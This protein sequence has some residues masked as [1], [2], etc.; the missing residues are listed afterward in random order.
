MGFKKKRQTES[1]ENL[2]VPESIFRMIDEI[3]KKPITPEAEK[4]VEE[5]WNRFQ[6]NSRKQRIGIIKKRMA[7]L[8][9]SAAAAMGLFISTAFVSPALAQ[10]ASQIPYLNLIFENKVQVKTLENEI[11]QA[12]MEKG[13]KTIGLHVNRKEKYIEAMVFN[14]A[15]YY[16]DTKKPIRDMISEILKARKEEKYQI[17]VA[18]DPEAFAQWS[19]AD[20]KSTETDKRII[21][22]EKTV[23]EVL[24]KY[25]Y[26]SP[27]HTSGISVD[28]V[29]LELPITESNIKKI[30]IEIKEK[31]KQRGLGDL[32]VKVYTYDP[33]LEERA[34]KFMNIVESIAT[35]LKAK[36]EY[37]I[38][39]VG[40]SNNKKEHF[41]ISI[42]LVLVSTDS[43]VDEVVSEIEKTVRDFLESDVAL[44][45]IQGEKYEVVISSSD[46]KKM[47]VIKN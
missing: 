24:G 32:E 40:F 16:E 31:L 11:N 41:Y 26:D 3:S 5:D 18:N 38:D 15:E 8:S 20:E 39:S 4:Q 28:R 13:F 1:I 30:P 27:R 25:H 21:E 47:R 29:N 34:G 35:G 10:V 36:P 43:E 37:Q 33:S 7:I 44:K 46:G 9:L 12:I 14:T 17:R 23:Y 22:I 2:E 42:E 45:A 19:K 6:R